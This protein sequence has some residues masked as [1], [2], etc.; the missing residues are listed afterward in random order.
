MNI[1]HTISSLRS[2]LEPLRNEG[3]RIGFVPT[4]GALHNGHLQLVA[5]AAKEN[6]VCVVSI[7]VNPTQF[8]DKSDLEKYPRTPEADCRLLETVGCSIV[9]LPSVEEMYPEEDAR[10]FDFSPL[11]EVMEG[12]LRPGHFNGVGQ[13]VSKLFDAVMPHK[14]YFGLKDFQQLA[15]IQLMVKQMNFPIEI[16][17]CPIVRE[18][19]GL[20]MS[21]RNV[22]LTAEQ[23]AVAP[24]IYAALKSS[25]EMSKT[26]SLEVVKRSVEEAIR[27]EP[28]FKLDYFEIVDGRTLQSIGSWNQTDYPV[29]CIALYCG[30]VRLIDNIAYR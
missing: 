11:D 16:V 27:R 23:R 18:A 29:G 26:E 17:P 2:V 3:K 1:I 7:F 6:D 24:A 22:R 14:A 9:F 10:I 28:L 25:V 30:P 13:V 4:M 5:R 19:D 20:A 21:S 8:N 12:P 15:I